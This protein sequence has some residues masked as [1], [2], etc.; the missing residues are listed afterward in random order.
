VPGS[1]ARGT[2]FSNKTYHNTERRQFMRYAGVPRANAHD[3]RT[4]AVR[5]SICTI[6]R[7]SGAFSRQTRA[8]RHRDEMAYRKT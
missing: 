6:H 1:E 4:R 7:R 5:G 8:A 2:R 3:V